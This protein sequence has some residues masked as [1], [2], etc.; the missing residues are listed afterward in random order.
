M[1]KMF[2][3]GLMASAAIVTLSS[4]AVASD[5]LGDAWSKERFQIRVRAIDVM[6]DGDGRVTQNGLKTDVEHAITPE[7]DLTYFF[8]KNIAAELIAATSQHEV[9]AG[10]FNLGEAW[11]LPPTLTLQYHFTPDNAF[12]PYVGAGL[13]YSMFYGEEDGNGFN[14]LDVDGGIGYAVQAGFDYWLNDNWGLNLDA[15]YINLD[16]DVDVDLGATHLD[17]DDVDLDPFIIGAGVSYRF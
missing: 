9:D 3:M 7:V 16:V 11:I 10:P 8:T 15:K 1:K 4:P 17:A 14:N 5:D 6:A 13:N 2:K 12:S